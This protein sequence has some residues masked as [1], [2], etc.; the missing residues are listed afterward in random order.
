M[1]TKGD[2]RWHLTGLETATNVRSRDMRQNKFPRESK[3]QQTQLTG[4][5]SDNSL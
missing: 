4:I 2:T 1:L 5:P 3:Q